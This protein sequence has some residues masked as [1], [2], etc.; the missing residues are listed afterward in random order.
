MSNNRMMSTSN[1]L[2]PM[3]G[4]F[5]NVMDYKAL[6]DGIEENMGSKTAAVIILAAG[7]SYGK[8]IAIV[9]GA[10][11]ETKD[12]PSVLQRLNTSLGMEGTRMCVIEEASQQE[13]FIRVKVVE[14]LEMSGETPGS[15]RLCPFTMGVLG[16]FIDQ[17]MK[18]R[19]Q[20]RQ[21]SVGE[22]VNLQTEFEFTPL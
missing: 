17:V 15:N 22:Q 9:L 1:S 5:V 7:R 16:G 12:L 19:H 11:Q 10:T 21:V 18:K 2:R 6:L 8:K 4:D 13:G 14:P 3:L 20:G